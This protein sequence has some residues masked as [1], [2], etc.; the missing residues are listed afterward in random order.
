MA[1]AKNYQCW[2]PFMKERTYKSIHKHVMQ[3]SLY[4]CS[5]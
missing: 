5:I 4:C 1:R 3:T 2:W